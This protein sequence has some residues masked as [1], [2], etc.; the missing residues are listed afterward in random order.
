MQQFLNKFCVEDNSR[1]TCSDFELKP[2]EIAEIQAEDFDIS[3]SSIV[4]FK[5]CKIS[6]FN[7]H[8]LDKFKNAR[9]VK[10]DGCE[11]NL[12]TADTYKNF[13]LTSLVFQN[14]VFREI[15]NFAFRNYKE[16]SSV[17]FISVNFPSTI[18]SQSLFQK[19]DKLTSLVLVYSE[20]SEIH[21]EIFSE[22]IN[23]DFLLLNG[24]S[25]S[26]TFRKRLLEKNTKLK[27][28]IASDAKI[29]FIEPNFFP[30]SIQNIDLS[31]NSLENVSEDY[32]KGLL[33][34]K[35]LDIG[36]NKIQSIN[37]RAFDDQR[38]LQ[39]LHLE[40]NEMKTFSKRQFKNLISLQYLDVIGNIGADESLFEDLPNINELYV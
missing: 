2:T 10:F 37:E 1:L 21:E 27:T 7:E 6:K 5:K 30:R 40:Y 25:F 28:F 16:L 38:N 9:Y 12:S 32:F 13:P 31:L 39:I 29:K 22:I 3:S 36:N 23:L 18:L 8:F 26:T 20:L 35:S 24:N 15:T 34:L 19:N 4:I 11:L 33:A 17:T 14:C